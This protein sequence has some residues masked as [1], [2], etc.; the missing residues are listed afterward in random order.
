MVPLSAG[1]QS[2]DAFT[3]ARAADDGVWPQVSLEESADGD[4]ARKLCVR[5]LGKKQEEAGR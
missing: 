1:R 3:T 2:R 5:W 4:G